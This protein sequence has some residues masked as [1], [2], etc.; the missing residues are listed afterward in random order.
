MQK[1]ARASMR[2]TLVA[3]AGLN[4]QTA[5]AVHLDPNGTGQVL[6]YPYYTVREGAGGGYNTLFSVV[7]HTGS[8][9]AVRVRFREAMRGAD[10]L[11][12]NLFLAP[13]DTW[14]GALQG[15]AEGTVLRSEDRSC[16]WPP[17]SAQGLPLVNYGYINSWSDGSTEALDRTREGYFEMI[18]MGVISQATVAAYA[19]Q[20]DNWARLAIPG[21]VP[22]APQVAVNCGELGRLDSETA[23]GNFFDPP[24][25]GLSGTLTL[26]N[27]FDGTD[28]S[29]NAVALGSFSDRVLWT[30]TGH[31]LPDLTQASPRVSEILGVTQPK[32]GA[33]YFR[34]EW[35]V[36]ESLPADPVSAVLMAESIQNEYVVDPVSRAAETAWVVTFPTKQHY[37]RRL[38]PPGEPA[39]WGALGLFENDYVDGAEDTLAACGHDRT[40]HREGG[41]GPP[42]A[43]FIGPC[44]R[45]ST[46]TRWASNVLN[47]AGTNLLGSA[48]TLPTTTRVPTGTP[49]GWRQLAWGQGLARI[50]ERPDRNYSGSSHVLLGGRTLQVLRDGTLIT[51][52]TTTYFGLPAIGFALHRWA[53]H[54]LPTPSGPMQSNYGGLFPHKSLSRVE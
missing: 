2:I 19:T 33:G 36:A 47:F 24:A 48:V 13:Y 43:V 4:A 3:L 42:V 10:V 49:S 40:Y 16:T 12:F 8:V 23:M 17:I 22:L 1:K 34:T 51:T 11:N 52:G 27:V 9:K 53:Y 20:E 31:N 30:S 41:G 5:A 18:E 25:G 35:P 15:S 7:N 14:A 32:S 21:A 44:D 29:T 50:Y 38:A 6:L 37:Y 46:R 26:I 45:G 54:A 28:Y 39:R